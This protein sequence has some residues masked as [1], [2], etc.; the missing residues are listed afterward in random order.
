MTVY[1]SAPYNSNRH[2]IRVMGVQSKCGIF[3]PGPAF[4]G[5]PLWQPSWCFYC[6]LLDE[7]GLHTLYYPWEAGVRRLPGCSKSSRTRDIILFGEL[8]GIM[9]LLQERRS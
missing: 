3:Y 7:H 5:W 8:R 2:K 1:A 9:A 6:Y 4:I